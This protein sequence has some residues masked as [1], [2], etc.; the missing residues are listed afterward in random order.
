VPL[1]GED[2]RLV[3]ELLGDVLADALHLPA[4]AAGGAWRLVADLAA[5]QVCR[6]R[7]SLGLSL[8]FARSVRGPERLDL[9][10]HRRQVSV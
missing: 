9:D 2:A 3:V 1:D 7:S 10:G 5:R 6:Q 8:L 4:A